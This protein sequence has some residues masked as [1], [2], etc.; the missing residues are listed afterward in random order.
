MTTA[1]QT[2]TT[3]VTHLISKTRQKAID[4]IFNKIKELGESKF[5]IC[6][7]H[8]S[9]LWV[10]HVKIKPALTDVKDNITDAVEKAILEG[11]IE[12]QYGWIYYN[13]DFKGFFKLMKETSKS[14]GLSDLETKA[15][16]ESIQSS[17][18]TTKEVDESYKK[19]EEFHEVFY[20]SSLGIRK[21]N[22]LDA[23]IRSKYSHSRSVT[24][25]QMKDVIGEFLDF[26][27]EKKKT[28]DE[29]AKSIGI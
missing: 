27:A 14:F 1:I 19:S 8:S 29:L 12:D 13:D 7:S 3:T 23:L 17:E 5:L 16:F 28:I 15:L 11:L 6:S 9:K 21:F 24:D 22:D 4:N 26:A 25:Q 2:A 20:K 10:S 18:S